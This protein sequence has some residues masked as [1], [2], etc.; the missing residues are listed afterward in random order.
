MLFFR[1]LL[2]LLGAFRSIVPPVLEIAANQ[3]HI[4]V[5]NVGILRVGNLQNCSFS[6]A[7]FRD[8]KIGFDYTPTQAFPV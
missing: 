5:E 1:H 4:H 6:Q 7:Q 8:A 2:C 3:R